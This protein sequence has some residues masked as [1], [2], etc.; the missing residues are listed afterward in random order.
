MRLAALFLVALLAG[1]AAPKPD[2]YAGVPPAGVTSERVA[3]AHEQVFSS[4]PFGTPNRAV[5]ARVFWNAT[6]HAVD[7][8]L[9]AGDQCQAYGTHAFHPVASLLNST[10]GVLEADL[11]AGVSN[12]LLVDNTDYA[13][14]RAPAGADVQLE[15]AIQVWLV[16][17]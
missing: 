17:S 11:P 10:G 1:C 14:G 6:P 2:P 16:R 5:H 15:Y 3:I 12:C 4:P 9:A 7:A 13:E 8:W